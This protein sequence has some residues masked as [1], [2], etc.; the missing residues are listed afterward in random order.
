MGFLKKKKKDAPGE[1]AVEEKSDEKSKPADPKKK[2]LIKKLSTILL[3]L[4]ILGGLGGGS[5]AYTKFFAGSGGED[6]RVYQ[7]ISLSHVTLPEEMLVFCFTRMPELYDALVAFNGEMVLFET[8][9]ARIDAVGTKYPDQKKIADGQKKEWDKGMQSLKKS[10]EKLEKPIKE[11]FVL[12]QVNQTLGQEKIDQ[13]AEQMTQAA[14]EALEKAQ[15]LTGPL[16]DAMPKAPEGMIKG[17]LYKIKKM[18]L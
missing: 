18:F 7:S 12:F 13:T 16:K 14:N 15:E 8:E 3:I 11:T 1:P 10:F 17:T 4:L 2:P 9:I 6:G 5:F